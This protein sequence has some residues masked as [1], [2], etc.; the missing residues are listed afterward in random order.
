VIVSSLVALLVAAPPADRPVV[1]QGRK[2]FYSAA[3][4]R[5]GMACADCH[6]VVEDEAT[7]GDGKLRAGHTLWGS[8]GRAYWRGDARK[9]DYPNLKKALDACAKLFLG[10]D[11]TAEDGARLVAYLE[12]I[13]PRRGQPPVVIQPALEANLDYDR[14]KYHGGDS[15]RGRQLFF[16][17]CHSCHPKGAAGVGPAI[18]GKPTAHIARTVREGNGLLRGKKIEGTFH[19]FYGKDRLTDAEVADIAAFIQSGE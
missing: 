3:L 11:V 1:S 18:T 2:V 8:A 12:S 16:A 14:D 19:G 5:T 6:A 7:Q 17:A 13:S 10:T 4:G 15:R 9:L